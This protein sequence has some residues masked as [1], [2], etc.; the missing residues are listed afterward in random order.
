MRHRVSQRKLNVDSEHRKALLKNL[1]IA[2][3]DKERIITTDEKSKEARRVAEKLITIA[4]KNDLHSR[5]LA[6]KEINN[7]DVVKKLFDNIAPRYKERQ[8]GYTRILKLGYRK[9]DAAALS[10]FELV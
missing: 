7:K 8:G 3:F 5:R 9:G 6:M 2:L 10:L 4:K 1:V